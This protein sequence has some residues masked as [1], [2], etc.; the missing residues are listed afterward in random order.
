[1]LTLNGIKVAIDPNIEEYIE[2]LTLEFDQEREGLI[3]SGRDSC[4]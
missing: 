1:M 4:C 2:G 3:L